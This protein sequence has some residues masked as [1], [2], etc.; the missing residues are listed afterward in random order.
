MFI[1]TF[2]K[3]NIKTISV[4]MLMMICSI[5]GYKYNDYKRDSEA[6]AAFEAAQLILKT[7]HE[8]ES[9][10]ASIVE[11]HL[12]NLRSNERV[13]ERERIKIIDRPIYQIECL[14]Q[15]GLDL[16]KRYA[17]GASENDSKSD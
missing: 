1:L 4:I 17:L 13:I 8:R 2:I 15:D 3:N 12:S 11:Q 5:L 6:S 9:K 10:V 14:D 16:I 7:E